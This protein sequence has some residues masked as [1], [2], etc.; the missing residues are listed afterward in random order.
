M[1]EIPCKYCVY[2]VSLGNAEYKRKRGLLIFAKGCVPLCPY[3]AGSEL[4]PATAKR[5]D[6]KKS[7]R[8]A[9]DILDV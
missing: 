6:E 5:G 1:A 7:F 9:S 4:A 8:A 2:V 3:F